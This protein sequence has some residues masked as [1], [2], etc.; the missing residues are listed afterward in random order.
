MST[1]EA[2]ATHAT[3][4][5][6]SHQTQ[7]GWDGRPFAAFFVRAV[8]FVAPLAAAVAASYT[9]ASL[10]TRPTSN[11]VSILTWWVVL[12]LAGT[13]T[14]AVV[15]RVARRFLPLAALLRMTL[16]FPDEA[17]SR[18]AVALRSGTIKQ[19]ERRVAEIRTSGAVTEAEGAE[20]LLEL[21]A[22]LAQHD[23]FTRGH[24]ER[25]RAYSAMIGAELGLD[26]L[27]QSKLQWAGLIHDVGKLA[28]PAE[29]LNKAGAL[30]S[31]EFDVIKTHPTEGMTLVQP[32]AG[33]LGE[34]SLAVGEH[35]ERWDGKGYPTG[36]AGDQISLA[37]RI[38]AVADVFDVITAARSYKKPQS[39]AVARQELADNAGTQFDPQV[40][41]AF[42]N[43]SLG[44]LRLTMWPLSWVAN[45]PLIGPTVTAPAS[46]LV[47]TASLA[48]F[49]AIAG[50]AL[51][52]E[53]KPPDVLA[54]V[55]QEDNQ[56]SS[57]AS[58]S[59]LVI[60][61]GPTTTV[62][63]ASAVPFTEPAGDWATTSTTSDT[64]SIGPA[65]TPANG[66]SAT[67]TPASTSPSSSTASTNGS[68]TSTADAATTTTAA[69]NQLSDC[70]AAKAG[71]TNLVG[72]D[73]VGCDL[74]KIT[75]DGLDLRNADLTNADLT[76][77]TLT[78]FSLEGATLDDAVL[79]GGK[80]I[81]GSMVGATA[82]NIAGR[83]FQVLRVDMSWVTITNSNFARGGFEEVSFAF[84]TL[85][86]T[87]FVQVLFQGTNFNDAQANRT[88]FDQSEHR[89][90]EFYRITANESSFAMAII[91]D[92]RL[93]DA[94]FVDADFSTAVLDATV[95]SRADFDLVDLTRTDFS[96]ATGVPTN[97]AT[98]DYQ[99]TIC[100]G[101][102]RGQ[103]TPCW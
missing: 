3:P 46:G 73:L 63:S 50:G 34:W 18:Y 23:R 37:G 103:S 95:L 28:V 43:I 1:P 57:S 9:L 89:N 84:A 85:D 92:S 48:V 51:P 62:A 96:T 39:P 90:S 100:P 17:P 16:V 36:L 25:V 24:G 75:L 66:N 10:W 56:S 44:Q 64:A 29:I 53:S 15:D 87:S 6:D 94:H 33:W 38:V 41:R 69:T 70:E 30:T 27:E 21:A 12:V 79:E 26:K 99:A 72:A 93:D 49:T 83:W 59:E 2:T 20:A 68:T 45:L 47:A 22:A 40:V 101:N 81:D 32:L 97:F 76:E 35:H 65:T 54:A 88:W 19:L 52:D 78:N 7:P 102:S 42:L 58:T 71:E 14:M 91:R 8:V 86:D 13:I 31:E 67:T 98:A 74:S 11:A 77:T 4:V 61:E 82:D 80:F 60:P 5:P 55:V